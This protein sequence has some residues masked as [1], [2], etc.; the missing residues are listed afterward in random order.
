MIVVVINDIGVT[1]NKFKYDSPIA[2]YFYCM[3]ALF[4][5][6][7]L[8]KKRTWVIHILYFVCSIKPVKNSWKSFCV[9]GINPFL[10]TC[11]KK[12]LQTFVRERFNHISTCN[13]LSYV[14]QYSFPA[15][16]ELRWFEAAIISMSSG[17]EYG[18]VRLWSMAWQLGHIGRRPW[19]GLT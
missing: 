2:G 17:I 11:I 6:A 16:V 7:Q 3:K 14:C 19:T 4:V 9:I 12:V 1:A 10:V 15:N 8:V 18:G 5:A 13:L